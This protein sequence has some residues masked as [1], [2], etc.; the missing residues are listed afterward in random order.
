MADRDRSLLL[1]PLLAEASHHPALRERIN[2]ATESLPVEASLERK[3]E[4]IIQALVLWLESR[5]P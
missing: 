2:A 1:I 5:R 3:Q 4:A